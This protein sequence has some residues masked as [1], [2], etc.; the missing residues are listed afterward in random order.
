MSGLIRPSST[1]PLLEP[2]IIELGAPEYLFC[3]LPTVMVF[4]AVPGAP[5]VSLSGPSF[6]A[7][8]NTVKPSLPL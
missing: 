8:N 7:A 3:E 6:P 2:S 1:G 5:I 4:L